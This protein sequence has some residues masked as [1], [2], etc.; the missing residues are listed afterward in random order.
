MFLMFRLVTNSF[1]FFVFYYINPLIAC[2]CNLIKL[3]RHNKKVKE[4]IKSKAQNERRSEKLPKLRLSAIYDE[5]K[6]S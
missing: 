2:C 6:T 5:R 3:K 1:F 4:N